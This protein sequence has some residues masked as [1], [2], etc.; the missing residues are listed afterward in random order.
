MGN[1]TAARLE[2]VH[3]PAEDRIL[4]FC[5]DGAGAHWTLAL[6]RRLTG[7]LIH[8]VL[9][10]LRET[11]ETTQRVPEAQRA[12]A[13][14]M[15]HERLA[16]DIRR[17]AVPPPVLGARETGPPG[18]LAQ[19][20]TLGLRAGQATLAFFDEAGQATLLHLPRDRLHRFAAYLERQ[21]K[22]GDW[23]LPDAA[24][25]GLPQGPAGGR[26]PH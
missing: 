8:L 21:A 26:R 6:T 17:E 19:R 22:R 16:G 23:L 25:A 10:L 3:D 1:L 15:E 11:S 24:S 4:G 12:E 13:L 20:V 7:T 9:R 14:L 5:Q 18:R 2:L